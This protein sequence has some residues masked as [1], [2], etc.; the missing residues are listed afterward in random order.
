[1]LPPPRP[2][3]PH[4]AWALLVGPLAMFVSLAYGIPLLGWLKGEVWRWRHDAL[5]AMTF[6]MALI[7]LPN[8]A[9]TTVWRRG[10]PEAVVKQAFFR[11]VPGVA[12]GLVALTLAVAIPERFPG[13]PFQV[14]HALDVGWRIISACGA[15]SGLW[16][17]LG[18]W[19][20][21]R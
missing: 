20:T 7:L 10:Q 11:M 17:A 3:E 4:P 16:L 9:A 5:W 8:V 14:D 12:L 18:A 6:G 1:M 19:P 2:N 13:L 21:L 15:L